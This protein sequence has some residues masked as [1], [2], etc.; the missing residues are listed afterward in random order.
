MAVV[1]FS[2][3]GKFNSKNIRK[4][5]EAV[6][7]LKPWASGDAPVVQ[8]WTSAGGLTV[9]VGYDHVGW[10]TKKDAY[11]FARNT[12]TGDVES[13]GSAEP[14]RSDLTKD[15]TTLKFVMQ[16]SKRQVIGIYEGQDL[17]AITPDAEGNIT[18]DKPVAPK[19]ID[20]RGL[21]IAKDGDGANAV[22]FSRWLPLCRVTDVSDQTW[23][24][25]DEVQYGATLTAF[26]DPTVKTAVRTIWGG[27]G[28]DAVAMGFKAGS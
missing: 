1:G 10:C 7:L 3:I 11:A 22:Y 17:S 5:L 2:D 15:V 25:E 26:T 6:L 12:D 18:Y 24:S 21:L 19:T 14:T 16:E 27:P 20:Y 8:I 4:A 9:P 13:H 28:L 23:G